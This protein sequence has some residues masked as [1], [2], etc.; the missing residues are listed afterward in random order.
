MIRIKEIARS[1]LQ[2]FNISPSWV[3]TLL[4]GLNYTFDEPTLVAR[5]FQHKGFVGKMFD[6]GVAMGDVS[7]AFLNLGWKVIGFEPDLSAAKMTVLDRLAAHENFTVDTRAVSNKTGEQLT[8]Y[9]SEV[10]EGIAS[11]HSFHSSHSA[12]HQVNTVSLKDAAEEHDAQNVSFIK[13]DTEGND[14]NVLLGMLGSSISPK[15]IVCEFDEVKAKHTSSTL[16]SI[17]ALLESLDYFCIVCE[18]FPVKRYGDRHQFKRIFMSPAVLDDKNS[19]GNVIAVAKDEKDS[20]LS[21][22][23]HQPEAR[24]L[25]VKT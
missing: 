12:S 21:F 14:L 3:K 2:F 11:I 19:W 20:F 10:S 24:F 17:I 18:W 4:Y 5:Y 7:Q 16:E 13:I 15:L 23:K 9:T 22:L 8:F 25:A 6:V 1:I